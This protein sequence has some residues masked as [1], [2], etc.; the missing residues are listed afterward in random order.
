MYEL[1]NLLEDRGK[2]EMEGI[3]IRES[4]K[5]NTID[6][7]TDL[8]C[9]GGGGIFA[10]MAPLQSKLVVNVNGGNVT[11]NYAA[12]PS[13]VE[14]GGVKTK[15]VRRECRIEDCTKWAR[16]L[17][18]CDCHLP[19][20][21]KFKAISIDK[22]IPDGAVAIP[23]TGKHPETGKYGHVV[24]VAWVDE[25]DEK[26]LLDYSRKWSLDS[27]GRPQASR[28]HIKRMHKLIMGK[29]PENGLQVDHINGNLCDNRHSNLRWV[30]RSVNTR[31]KIVTQR[32]GKAVSS[33]YPGVSWNKA[34]KKWQA[35]AADKNGTLKHLGVFDSERDAA[36]VVRAFK[37]RID[38]KIGIFDRG[39]L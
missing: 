12:H 20:D 22:P 4:Q 24:G 38:P 23:I 31:N 5:P 11:V 6:R 17:G 2:I 10:G 29:P 34:S 26:V 30:T 3:V 8:C 16:R 27:D 7:L 39:E 19:Q 35:H 28:G 14:T 36:E 33:S 37:T 25:E 32:N 15:A 13:P 21:M 1:Q 18:Y 9:D